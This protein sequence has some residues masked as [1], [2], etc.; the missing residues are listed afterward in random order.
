M[1]WTL[2]KSEPDIME[3]TLWHTT[4]EDRLVITA[5]NFG[6]D[7]KAVGTTADNTRQYYSCGV[8]ITANIHLDP[9]ADSCGA[10]SQITMADSGSMSDNYGVP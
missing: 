1:D 7:H 3:W 10:D 8:Y 4:V 5:G 2:Y 9:T 6:V